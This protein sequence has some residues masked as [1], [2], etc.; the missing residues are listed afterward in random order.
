MKDPLMINIMNKNLLMTDITMKKNPK[1]KT[2]IMKRKS[3]LIRRM[4]RNM[5]T[6]LLKRKNMRK[7]NMKMTTRMNISLKMMQRV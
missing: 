1:K 6:S 2:R 4:R 5:K 3:I 7:T